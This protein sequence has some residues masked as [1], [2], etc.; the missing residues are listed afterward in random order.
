VGTSRARIPGGLAGWV[1]VLALGAC[2]R[3][4]L[5]LA[6]RTSVAILEGGVPPNV[7]VD[8][9]IEPVADHPPDVP[10]D[11]PPEVKPDAKPDAKPDTKPD[12]APD[13]KPDLPVERPPMVEAGPMCQPQPETCNGRDD[14]CDGKIDQGLPPIPCPNGGERY[15]VAGR[16]SECPR[17]CDVC[18]PG[19]QRECF[20]SFCTFWGVQLC[21]SDGRSF[22]ACRETDVPK[23]CK[24]I[25][26]KQMRSRALEQCCLD[27]GFCCL[28]EFD[29]NKNGDRTDMVGRCDTVMC[30]Q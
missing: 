3:S 24:A 19:S 17:R 23:A 9:A 4:P 14:D 2:G 30:G 5:D 16:Y 28:D 25:A 11:V 13:L 22:G 20:T 6:P 29:L 7:M 12:V 8:A 21:A 15:C 1:F 18:V 26:E 10:P 27:Q